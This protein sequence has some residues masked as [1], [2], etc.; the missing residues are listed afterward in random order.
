MFPL[1]SEVLPLLGAGLLLIAA[2]GCSSSGSSTAI[3]A[4]APVFATSPADATVVAGETATFTASASGSPTYQWKRNGADVS[5]ATGASYTT[6]ASTAADNNTV[7]SVTVQNSGGAVTS[8]FATLHVSYVLVTTQPSGAT[9]APGQPATLF[10]VASGSGTL[11]YQWTKDGAELPGAT[12][13][14]YTITAAALT[15]TGAYAC[16]VTNTLNGKM[17]T[18]TSIAASLAVAT[19]APVITAAPTDITVVAGNVATFSVMATDALS[20]QWYKNGLPLYGATAG[21]YTTPATIGGDDNAAYTAEVSNSMG[22]TTSSAAHLHVNYLRV[23][24]EPADAITVTGNMA[25]IPGTGVAVAEGAVNLAISPVLA[26]SQGATVQIQWFKDGAVLP[27]ATNPALSVSTVT[28]G[29]AGTYSCAYTS[30]LNGTTV[31]AQTAPAQIQVVGLPVITSQPAGATLLVG[32]SATL[33]VAATQVGAGNLSYQWFK[34]G[35]AL[36]DVQTSGTVTAVTGSQLPNFYIQAL[37]TGDTGDYTCRVTNTNRGVAA[38]VNSQVAH[39]QVNGSPQITAQPASL[40][41]TEGR[42]ASFTLAAQGPGTL[43][44]TWYRGASALPNS[45]SPTY[46]VPAATLGDSGATFHCVV[47]NGFPPDAVSQTVTLTVNPLPASPTLEA[48]SQIITKGQGVVFTYLFD[49]AKTATFGPAGG[50]A[51]AVISG[52]STVV[53]PDATTTYTLTVAGYAPVTQ[54]VTVRVYTPKFLYVVNKGDN[55][56]WQY[57]VN[58]DSPR[59]SAGTFDVCDPG[60]SNLANALVGNPTTLHRSTGS[61][62]VHAVATFDERLVFV[63]NIGDAS[64]SVFPVNTATAVLDAAVSGSPFVLPSGYTKPW[65][66][67]PDPSGQRLYVAC[68]EGVAVFSIDGTTGAL[69]A[70]PGLNYAIPGRLMGDLVMHPSG[71]SL[72]VCDPGHSV[73]RSLAVAADGSLS[74]SGAD[75][76]VTFASGWSPAWGTQMYSP[77]NLTLDRAGTMLFT[78]SQDA[79]A[80]AHPSGY[81]DTNAAIDS[82]Q[83]DPYTGVLGGHQSSQSKLM[84]QSFFLVNGNLQGNHALLFSAMSGADHLYDGYTD[85]ATGWFGPYMGTL[86]ADLNLASPTYGQVPGYF[87]DPNF[88]SIGQPRALGSYVLNGNYKGATTLIQDR[89]G[90]IVV[91]VLGPL[92]ASLKL[93][94]FGVNAQGSLAFMGSGLGETPRNTG[95]KPTHGFFL[96][97]LN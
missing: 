73:I 27:G 21:T 12:G 17:A 37:A 63:C 39:L 58:P 11:S 50:T 48:S 67:A 15:D 41:V 71:K 93:I 96:G 68:A 4:A 60:N 26:Q 65:C 88:G 23:A 19:A 10:V 22:K 18:A 84:Y 89:S 46:T 35:V 61:Q 94:A 57:P 40:T 54:L 45:N 9:V 92:D 24:T 44:Y 1:R 76:A 28:Q 56:I 3:V 47:S 38:V 53:F 29:T 95:S 75:M 25:I 78:R 90:R 31:T 42:P 30:T 5:G 81:E 79:L 36:K 7:Y 66:S 20:F 52:G 77:L 14:S 87:Q 13:A 83:I 80:F 85:D 86:A 51:T 34:N 16:K 33:S 91:P 49:P 70:E 6:P 8:G 72:Y 62:P 43:T 97:A 32:Q 74:P 64:V 55:N 2:V 82:Y 69:T 59:I